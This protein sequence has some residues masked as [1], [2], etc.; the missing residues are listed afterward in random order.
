[1]SD[2]S[3]MVHPVVELCLGGG[4]S[5]LDAGSVTF[6]VYEGGDILERQT[7]VVAG[8]P[9]GAVIITGSEIFVGSLSAVTAAEEVAKNM[10][11]EEMRLVVDTVQNPD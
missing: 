4:C 8:M 9:E 5:E 3:A 10:D 1:M 6:P 11:V 7:I 2:P